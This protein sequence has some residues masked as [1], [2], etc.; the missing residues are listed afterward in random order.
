MEITDILQ[1]PEDESDMDRKKRG[2]MDN[3]TPK[4]MD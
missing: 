4:S 2:K 1:I 3:Q